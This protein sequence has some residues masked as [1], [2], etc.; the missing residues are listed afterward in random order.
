[1]F[2]STLVH[3]HMQVK[4]ECTRG[5]TL[6]FEF[7]REHRPSNATRVHSG[8]TATRAI[9]S[10]TG[11]AMQV[12]MKW[13]NYRQITVVYTSPRA[14]ALHKTHATP[15]HT[16]RGDTRPRFCTN[17]CLTRP[18]QQGKATALPRY[19]KAHVNVAL[20]PS[21]GGEISCITP[22]A[23]HTRPVEAY[24]AKLR[25]AKARA[26][27]HGCCNGLAAVTATCDE[28]ALST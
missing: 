28:F 12:E 21:V 2:R 14:C 19:T 20:L 22:S 17:S 23:P 5:G 18:E 3:R 8:I 11:L 15:L 7:D 26:V 4:S 16:N 10:L 25:P 13:I 27:V 1:M 24:G 9:K 6:T